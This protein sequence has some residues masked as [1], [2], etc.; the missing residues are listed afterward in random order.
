MNDEPCI[1]SMYVNEIML[2]T[3]RHDSMLRCALMQQRGTGPNGAGHLVVQAWGCDEVL[4]PEVA[5]TLTDASDDQEV[6]YSVGTKVAFRTTV[7]E[8]IGW[9]FG[10]ATTDDGGC[11]DIAA[12]KHV[13][14]GEWEGWSD[15][16]KRLWGL[17]QVELEL[18]PVAR[19]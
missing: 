3:T 2:N 5:K 17:D 15:A 10:V 9:Q 11:R 16:R 1:M 6:W 7:Q 13:F 14:E 8:A 18:E 4:P 19:L 12:V